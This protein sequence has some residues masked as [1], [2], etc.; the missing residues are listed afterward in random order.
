M[1][2][3]LTVLLV[4][5]VPVAIFAQGRRGDE[6]GLLKGFGLSDAQV[7]QVT[8]I[9]NATREV[10]KA[11]MTHIRLVNAQIQEALLPASPDLQAINALIDKKAQL[12]AEIQKSLLSARVQLTKLM[13]ADNFAKYRRFVMGPMRNGARGMRRPWMEGGMPP[14]PMMQGGPAPQD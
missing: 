3:F 14:A 13:G 6:S 10:A 8:Q 12:R 4:L 5:L 9:E 7:A 11:D 1:K 2:R